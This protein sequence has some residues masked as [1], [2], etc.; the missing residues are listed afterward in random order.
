MTNHPPI[1]DTFLRLVQIDSPT[2]HE[3][4][5]AE[6]LC[7]MLRDLDAEVRTDAAGNVIATLDGEGDPILLSA[8]MDT[9]EPGRGIKPR[10]ADG[11]ITSDGTTILGSD[12]KSGIAVIL[13]VLRRLKATGDRHRPLDIVLSVSEEG[14]LVG[15]KRLDVAAV[16]AKV[17]LV[18]DSGGP[19]GTL[20]RQAPC[21]DSLA[22]TIHGKAAHA[23]TDPEKGINAIV[24]AAEAIAQ[25]PLGRIDAETTANIGKISGGIATN[26]VPDRVEIAGEARS[27]KGEKLAAQTSRMVKAFETAAAKHGAR[28]DIQVTRSYEAYFLPDDHP[29]IRH[30]VALCKRVG[31]EPIL[32]S[33]G[34][35]SDA[36]VYNAKG[37]QCV[38]TS[39]GMSNV[40]TTAEQ[41]A[42]A[43][44]LAAADLVYAVVTAV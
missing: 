23:G 34:G 11:I 25:M 8:H 40:H 17:G 4:Q 15:A 22:V 28:A 36:N 31:V 27:L 32:M 24:V 2:G 42:V 44:L 20:V 19:I 29:W 26:I 12:C 9:V 7:Q 5:L 39:T 37:I 6:T 41:I 18:L 14:G 10:I 35:G 30:L 21:Q 43:D 3:Q 13:D 38:V 16:R 33:S 1:V